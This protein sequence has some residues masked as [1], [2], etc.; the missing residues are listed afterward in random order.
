MWTRTDGSLEVR[1]VQTFDSCPY[2]AH[3]MTSANQLLVGP[4]RQHLRPFRLE[5]THSWQSAPRHGDSWSHCGAYASTERIRNVNFLSRPQWVTSENGTQMIIEQR[6]APVEEAPA[7]EATNMSVEPSA[8][9]TASAASCWVALQHRKPQPYCTFTHYTV[10]HG[11][12]ELRRADQ[13]DLLAPRGASRTAGRALPY[14][15]RR[16]TLRTNPGFRR[17]CEACS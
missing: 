14:A 2:G 17:A 12:P 11:C 13:E 3:R 5:H 16:S 7:V 9:V 6:S 15:P 8:D 4:S 10:T 1:H